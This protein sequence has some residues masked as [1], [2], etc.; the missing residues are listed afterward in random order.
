[1]LK[2]EPKESPKGKSQQPSADIAKA[3]PSTQTPSTVLV[4]QGKELPKVT[5]ATPQISKADVNVKE[6]TKTTAPK[7]STD[8]SY[9]ASKEKQELEKKGSGTEERISLDEFLKPK[10]RRSSISISSNALGSEPN[11]SAS[12]SYQQDLMKERFTQE[13]EKREGAEK[14]TQQKKGG[15]KPNP[16]TSD[17][18]PRRPALRKRSKT[19]NVSQKQEPSAPH[20]IKYIDEKTR[21]EQ[22]YELNQHLIRKKTTKEEQTNNN[23]STASAK[24]KVDTKEQV[25]ESPPTY[26][27]KNSIALPYD[28]LEPFDEEEKEVRA[29]IHKE[30]SF[31]QRLLVT[32]NPLSAYYRIRVTKNSFLHEISRCFYPEFDSSFLQLVPQDYGLPKSFLVNSCCCYITR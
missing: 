11:A 12:L 27:R 15:S 20:F 2:Q 19:L 24:P 3:K 30:R 7:T 26:S 14:Q 18:D 29:S 1:M 17:W 4:T 6:E 32:H 25:P 13:L 28:P 22:K 5:T 23:R 16:S 21:K 9:D 31:E 10:S 8:A